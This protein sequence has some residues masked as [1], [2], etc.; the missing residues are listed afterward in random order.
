MK[1][2]FVQSENESLAVELF[3]A[4]LK[5]KGHVTELAYDNRYF[6]RTAVNLP[7]LA[8]LFDM[9][10]RLAEDVA[11]GKPDL[12]AF[13]VMTSGYQWAVDM[14]RRIKRAIDV[15]IVFGGVHVIAVPEIVIEEDCI[16]AVCVGEGEVPLVS[17]VDQIRSFP[18]VDVPGMWIKRGAK[19]VT[20]E[21]GDMVSDLDSLPFPD[22]ELFYDKLPW[23]SRGYI[24]MTSRGCPY[25]CTFCSN[26]MLRRLYKGRVQYVRRRSEA[27]VLDE[28]SAAVSRYRPDRF[29][30]LDDCFT[31]DK[32]WLAR[33]CE[34]YIRDIGVPFI[35]VSHPQLVNDDVARMLAEANC[36]QILLGVQSAS[37]S[38]RRNVLNRRES[39]EQIRAA[40]QACHRNGLRFSVDHI[41]G[42]PHEGEAEYRKAFRFYN[43]LRP[44]A[45]NTYYLVYFPGTTIIDS[46]LEA[47]ILDAEDV[48][49]IN[50]GE[51]DISM[52]VGI[53]AGRKKTDMFYNYAFLLSL[54]P[55]LPR[56]VIDFLDRREMYLDGWKP[57]IALIMILRV[58]ALLIV[59]LRLYWRGSLGMARGFLRSAWRTTVRRFGY[60][61]QGGT[62]RPRS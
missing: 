8:N 56:R 31:A 43:E 55:L 35:A 1:V 57:H 53:G 54:I 29:N 20:S 45:I 23:L 13:S 39:N 11:S 38:V 58:A 21:P 24:I 49:R 14:A 33:F 47:G 26:D 60:G 34:A 59:D 41:F 22:K 37:E 2:T 46:A 50:R 62:C 10:D 40:A 12:V 16:D 6:S 44:N 32:D 52:N 42:I 19:V 7:G 30:I 25:A 3:S 18:D 4:L 36:A 28:M 5:E 48:D 61:P 15:P 9:R 17:L 51:L 27:D